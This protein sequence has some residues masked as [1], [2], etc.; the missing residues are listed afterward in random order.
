MVSGLGLTAWRLE[1]SW[2]QIIGH[3]SILS[4]V[5][6]SGFDIYRSDL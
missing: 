3:M 1:I 4:S 6:S 5:R 2:N